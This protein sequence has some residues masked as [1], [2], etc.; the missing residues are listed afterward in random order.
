[1]KFY[2]F[3]LLISVFV[4]GV[5][6]SA[7]DTDLQQPE[8][9]LQEASEAE[10]TLKEE[11]TADNQADSGDPETL[12]RNCSETCTLQQDGSSASCGTIV[13]FGSTTF[14]GGCKKA[15]RLAMADAQTKVTPG[16]HIAGACIESCN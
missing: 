1:M 16:C 2:R 5:S 8:P 9:S 15:C 3:A 11:E 7:C 6:S 12:A 14:L 13:G 10:Q 4:V